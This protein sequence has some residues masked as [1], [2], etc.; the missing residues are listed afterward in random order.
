V[1]VVVEESTLSMLIWL[2]V[3]LQLGERNHPQ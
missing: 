2:A 3:L 1:N